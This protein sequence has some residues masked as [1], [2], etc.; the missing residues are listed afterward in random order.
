MQIDKFPTIR[1]EDNEFMVVFQIGRGKIQSVIGGMDFITMSDFTTHF[2][3][4]KSQERRV[5][6]HI[7]MI[8]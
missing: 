2:T 4:G 6:L 7:W 3:E 8:K 5:K 1:R